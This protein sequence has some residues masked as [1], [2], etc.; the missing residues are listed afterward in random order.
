MNL[1]GC[2]R[3]DGRERWT[4]WVCGMVCGDLVGVVWGL[5]AQLVEVRCES[6]LPQT[7]FFETF[8]NI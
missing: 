5:G 3:R 6:Q 7:E 2:S 1:V 8:R 4:S